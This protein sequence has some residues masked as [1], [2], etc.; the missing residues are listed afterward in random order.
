MNTPLLSL[1]GI[2]KR[3]GKTKVLENLSLDVNPGEF[4]VLIGGS[5]SG[6]TTAL[7]L[8]AGLARADKGTISLR[9]KAADEPAKGRFTPPEK[10]HLGM[11]FQDY[12]LW[13]HFTCLQN[14]AAAIRGSVQG[15][16]AQAMALLERVGMTAHAKA[17]PQ[18]LSGGQ[19]QRIGVARA[20]AA[21]PDFLL[22]DEALSSL[23]VDIR[24][25]LRMEIRGLARETGAAG[26]FVSHDPIDAWRL[27]DR[28]AVLEHGRL[29]QIA[30][31]SELYASPSTARVARFIGAAG[32][33]RTDVCSVNGQPGIRLSGQFCPATPVDMRPG[34][35][36]V[37][38]IRPEGIRPSEDGVPAELLFHTFEAGQHR[39]YWRLADT[40]ATVCSLEP[41]WPT[42]VA[43]ALSIAAEHILIYPDN[44]DSPHD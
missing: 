5:G 31:P 14:V 25:H 18:Q 33:F 21:K 41:A 32:G 28:V 15:R 36:G 7:R 2:H 20:L 34:Q 38:Y 19:Q 42:S 12:A 4:V 13:P 26:L 16:E 27:A 9:G 6:K 44:E 1:Q 22:F 8:V 23:D 43:A 37:V 17:R 35:R 10:R 39:V 40:G 3:Y 30:P 24:E 29:T 11:V